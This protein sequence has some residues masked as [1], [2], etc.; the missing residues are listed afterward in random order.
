MTR[1]RRPQSGRFPRKG[2]CEIT[3]GSLC[4]S[5]KEYN[6][7]ISS[8]S[9]V[10]T[11][12]NNLVGA[13]ASAAVPSAPGPPADFGKPYCRFLGAQ[14][15]P[16]SALRSPQDA[17]RSI[18]KSIKILINFRHRFWI[19]FGSFWDPKLAPLVAKFRPQTVLRSF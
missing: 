2:L 16:K 3:R 1:R 12:G 14:D 7:T 4:S 11:E 18:Q 6:L 13:H 17:P 8:K 5:F 10:I 19:D 9:M 15:P